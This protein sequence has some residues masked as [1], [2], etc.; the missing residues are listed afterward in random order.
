MFRRHVLALGGVAAF[1]APIIGELAE[2]VGPSPAPLPSQI[3]EVHVMKVRALTQWLRES[4]RTYGADAQVS[5]GAAAWA[6][7]LL[8]VPGSEPVKRAL[9]VAVAEL[10]LEAGWSGFECATRRCCVRMEVRDRPFLCRR[11]GEVKLEAA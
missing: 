11:S 4:G 7:R 5:S 10:E 1:S 9:L 6:T 2:L 3:F 8:R